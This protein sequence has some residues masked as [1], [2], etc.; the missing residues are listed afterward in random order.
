MNFKKWKNAATRIKREHKPIIP[1]LCW[2]CAKA[3]ATSGCSWFDGTY[4]PVE[5]WEAEPTIIHMNNKTS[6]K[7]SSFL[8]KKCPNYISDDVL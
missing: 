4:T 1:Q 2:T 5:G 7:I 3:Y 8:I 6:P